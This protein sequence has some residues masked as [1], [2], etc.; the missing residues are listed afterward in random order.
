MS[1]KKKPAAV[2]VK[3][4]P[5]NEGTEQAKKEPTLT[6]QAVA[7]VS[8]LGV[9]VS[10]KDGNAVR[11]CNVELDGVIKR[12]EQERTTAHDNVKKLQEEQSAL[13]FKILQEHMKLQELDKLYQHLNAA[14]GSIVSLG[15]LD[16]TTT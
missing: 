6:E 3:D 14:L 8:K 5:K 4:A 1:T 7:L 9:A 16:A 12:L 10:K 13:A 2:P 11:A 15:E